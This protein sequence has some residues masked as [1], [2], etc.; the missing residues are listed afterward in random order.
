MDCPPV[1][2]ICQNT[3]AGDAHWRVNRPMVRL[4]EAGVDARVCWLDGD[5]MPVQSVAGR[6]V[7]LSQV[8]AEGGL[9]AA[10]AW[11]DRLRAAG[12]AAVVYDTDDDELTGANI[13]H[14]AA[15]QP[16]GA[17]DRAELEHQR[18]GRIDT[19]RACDGA[20]VTTEPLAEVVRSYTDRPVIVV[21]NA[22]DVDWFRARLPERAPWADHPTIGWAGWRRPDADLEPMAEAW[23]RIARRHPDVRFVIAGHQADVIYRQDIDLDRIIRVP[24]AP[25]DRYPVMHQVNIG[26]AAVADSPFSR[27]KTPIKLFEFALAGAAVVATKALYGPEMEHA[28]YYFVES[29]DHWEEVLS[30]LVVDRWSRVRR[31][32]GLAQHVLTEHTL[33]ANLHRWADAYAEIAASVGVPA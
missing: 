2:F 21:P 1:L 3:A 13:D 27:C 5:Q 25:L 26:C 14:L 32:A 19:L 23:A 10:R 20:T 4:K 11:T 9:A 28:G 29:A 8:A 6:V 18:R 22:I 12:A 16:L 24:I 31:A 30:G 17:S 7:V 33:A 15:T